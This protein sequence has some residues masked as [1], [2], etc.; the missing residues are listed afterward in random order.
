MAYLPQKKPAWLVLE[1]G[2]VFKGEAFGAPVEAAGR[3]VFNTACVGYQ[4]L[5][6][7]PESLGQVIIE[8]FPCA[9]NYGINDGGD[10]SS[11]PA[12]AGFIV[13]EWC[14][15]PSNFLCTGDI[16]R[17]LREKGIP[18]LGGIDTRALVRSVRDGGEL[19][20]LITQTEPNVPAAI[21]KIRAFSLK[22][23]INDY[24][25]NKKYTI[26]PAN[27]QLTATLFDF[28]CK[29]SFLES[30]AEAGFSLTVLPFCELGKVRTEGAVILSGGP[31][32]PDCFSEQLPALR[33]LYRAGNP[34]FAVG[35]SH[36]LLAQALGGSLAV[37][38]HGH[39]GS[40]IPATD[41]KSGRT[42]I[43]TQNHRLY[44]EK[45]AEGEVAFTH[46]AD[47]SCE[48]IRYKSA[49]SVQFIPAYERG[50]MNTGDLFREF[51]K[52]L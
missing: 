18:G 3:L 36:L 10:E 40:N 41:K 11:H 8:A 43:T 52:M 13:R 31:E 1:D 37:L 14:E 15:A 22:N 9:G 33:E 51:I 42:L 25:F 7:D 44:V 30:L 28:G 24:I 32:E 26:S 4:Q 47:G 49:L 6:T 46:A 21:E 38:R 20:C 29:R 39:R 19:G 50:R 17:Y 27:P 48:G 23:R 12:A 5:L 2:R 35:L 34:I 45:A 16:D